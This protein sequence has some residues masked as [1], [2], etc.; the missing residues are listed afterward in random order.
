[1]RKL[2]LNLI[3]FYQ[4]YLAWLNGPSVCRFNP[5]CSEYTDQAIS[6]YGILRG[7]LLGTKRILSCN[8]WHKYEGHL[9]Q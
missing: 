5:S 9:S 1:M 3:R 6:K 7:L 4:N 2:A 8:P